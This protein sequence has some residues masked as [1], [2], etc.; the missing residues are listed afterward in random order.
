MQ[1][2]IKPVCYR[3]LGLPNRRRGVTPFTSAPWC[4]YPKRGQGKV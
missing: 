4:Q 2:S 3:P 1:I